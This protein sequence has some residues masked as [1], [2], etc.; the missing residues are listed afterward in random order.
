[1]IIDVEAFNKYKI[2]GQSRDDAVGEAFDKVAKLIGLGYPGGP[3]IE[4]ISKNGDPKKFDFPQPMLHSPNYD[5]SFSGLKTAVLYTV[6]GIQEMDKQ[7]QADIAASFQHVV[8]EVL[9]KKVSK[10]LE[11][12][13]RKSIVM[14]GGV[15][16]NK[17]LR[18]KITVLRDKLN[19]NVLYPPLAHCT[20]NAA[21]VAYLGS[22]K[23]DQAEY[24]LF[25]QAR[26]RW[27]LES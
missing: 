15:A 26:P 6:Q 14:T 23:Y 11:D 24:N 18:D 16:A 22:L 7:I 10:A 12:T 9:I 17:L 19:I 2:L 4:K 27:S 13:G 25:S 1:M 8:T 21:M 20:D 5:F 3:E